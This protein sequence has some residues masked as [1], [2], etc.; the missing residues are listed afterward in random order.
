MALIFVTGVS[1]AGKSTVR[2]ELTRRGFRAYDTDEDAIAQWTNRVSG[3][4]TPLV[5]ATHRTPEFIAQNDWKADPELVRQLAVEGHKR[6]VFLCG[7]VG[8][9]DEIRPFF[10]KVFLLTID[11]ATMRHRLATRTAHD[12]GTKPHELELLLVW[13]EAINDH[14]LGQGAIVIDATKP[15]PSVVD[16]LLRSSTRSEP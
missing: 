13:R 1:G 4:V 5:D 2:E 3:T 11:E 8:N 7:S 6:T 15:P 16:E 10:D 12:F 14:Y 9:D